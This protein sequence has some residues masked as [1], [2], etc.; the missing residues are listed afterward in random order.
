MASV[1]WSLIDM[2]NNLKDCCEYKASLDVHYL[3]EYL[4]KLY[5]Y[6]KLELVM[7]I[8]KGPLQIKFKAVGSKISL[9]LLVEKF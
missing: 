1:S 6:R 5:R 2:C 8:K 4:S 3:I 9:W 7:K